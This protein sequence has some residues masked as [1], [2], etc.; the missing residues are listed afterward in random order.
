MTQ[1]VNH[2]IVLWQKKK[3]KKSALF[4]QFD[5]KMPDVSN[6][7]LPEDRLRNTL[8]REFY[9]IYICYLSF[10]WKMFTMQSIFYE[11]Y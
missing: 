5:L 7:N 1:Y 6:T 10:Q 2:Q 9:Y 11:S 3:K 4:V 8:S